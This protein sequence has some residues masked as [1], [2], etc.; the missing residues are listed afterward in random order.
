MQSPQKL[1]ERLQT[2]HKA[3]ETANASLQAELTKIGEEIASLGRSNTRYGVSGQS[4]TSVTTPTS[5]ADDSNGI[6]ALRTKLADMASKQTTASSS[7]TTRLDDL[8]TDIASSLQVSESRL[9]KLDEL[10]RE[11]S[12]ENEALYSRF[13]EEL[14]R[15]MS[16]VRLGEGE[17]EM[18]KR[19]KEL[20][21]DNERLRR[22]NGRMR[23][24]VIGLRAQLKE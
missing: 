14:V 13:N 12:A 18:R 19:M 2:E 9:K 20:E 17:M 15:V 5:L 7:M 23:R 21:D 8:A 24:E 10:Y 4:L 22:E 1:R 3:G 6:N 16:R 11:A